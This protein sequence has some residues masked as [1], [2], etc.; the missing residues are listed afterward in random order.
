MEALKPWQGHSV[1][2]LGKHFILTVPLLTKASV[3]VGVQLTITVLHG[4]IFTV[5]QKGHTLKKLK[6]LR[7]TKNLTYKLKIVHA[8]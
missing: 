2:L 8:N 1:V 3:H 7:Q 6:K 5:A 4:H